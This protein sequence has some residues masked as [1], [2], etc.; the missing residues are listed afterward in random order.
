MRKFKVYHKFD[1]ND[2]LEW[3]VYE[4]ATEQVIGVYLFEEDAMEEAWRLENGGGFDGFTPNFMLRKVLS[5]TNINDAFS[6]EFGI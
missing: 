5:L 4:K 3:H 1:D 2:C 6:V